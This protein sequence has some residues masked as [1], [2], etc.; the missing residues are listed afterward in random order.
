MVGDAPFNRREHKEIL[1]PSLTGP[2]KKPIMI[3]NFIFSRRLNTTFLNAD[4]MTTQL[5]FVDALLNRFTEATGLHLSRPHDPGP[6]SRTVPILVRNGPNPTARQG[7]VVPSI[8][9]A[10][11]L[12]QL[13]HEL[14]NRLPGFILL[15]QYLTPAMARTCQDLGLA[16]IDSAGNAFVK[17]G[18][19]HI[20]I[21]GKKLAKQVLRK[22]KPMRA[23]SGTG[24]RVV[25]QLL[26]RPAALTLTVRELSALSG[27]SVG[28]VS[29]VI[30]DLKAQGFLASRGKTG[31]TLIDAHRLGAA[32]AVSYPLRLRPNLVV[33]RFQAPMP[34]WWKMADLTSCRAQ[35]SGE[36]AAAILTQE[37]G[38]ATTTIYA[39]EDP[40]GIVGRFRLKAD[41][42]GSVELLKAF[43]DPS[44]LELPDPRVVP[45][46]IAYADL[47]NLGDP[48]A[49][50]AAGWL[51]ERYLAPP[52]FPH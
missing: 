30:A 14:G 8:D 4:P 3:M 13:V 10:A 29:G 28:S 9:R 46:L 44:G 20:L 7:L 18:R 38:P 16:F 19:T 51:D 33:G 49:A 25:F 43:W 11:T 5:E 31:L 12:Y 45:P 34:E 17:Q 15:T 26:V 6:D 48:R 40:K 52:S 24:L 41:P 2:P 42:E 1:N 22:S 35:W 37:F 36:V 50:E 32:W 21:T 47:L 27:A 23:L 39:S